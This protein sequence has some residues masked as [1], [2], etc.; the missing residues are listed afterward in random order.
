MG[1]KRRK[2]P[3]KTPPLRTPISGRGG[4]A[5][6]RR[7]KQS[8]DCA[9]ACRLNPGAWGSCKKREDEGGVERFRTV[10]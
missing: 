4:G 2:R 1:W 5:E 9:G 7:Q 6:R 3:R 10:F 8:G